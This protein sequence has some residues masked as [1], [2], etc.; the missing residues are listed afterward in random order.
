M[1]HGY[2]SN[3]TTFVTLMAR[4][5]Q[6]Y[7]LVL[8]D[9]CGWGLNT[10]LEQCEGLETKETAFQWLK[11]FICRAIDAM[12]LP[13]TFLLAG[14]SY[15]G[16]LAA[17]YATERQQRVESLFLLSPCNLETR[18]PDNYEPLAYNDQL[19]PNLLSDPSWVPYVHRK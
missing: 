10:R 14:H 12:D 18:D 8:F 11:N 3:C 1:T 15:G 2:M 13:E 5:A 4:L 6:H 7:D 17:L 16:W 9:N 19:H